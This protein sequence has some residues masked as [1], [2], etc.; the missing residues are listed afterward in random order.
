MRKWFQPEIDFLTRHWSDYTAK[1]IGE[2]LK[3]SESAVSSMASKLGL[4]KSRDFKRRS[5]ARAK[6]SFHDRY[7]LERLQNG[8]KGINY[9]TRAQSLGGAAEELFHKLVP[10]AVNANES[11]GINNPDFDFIYKNLTIDVKYSSAHKRRE[12]HSEHWSVR[13]SGNMDLIVGFLEK[14][15]G[16]ELDEPYIIIIPKKLCPK[17]KIEVHKN[18]KYREMF[19]DKSN[20]IATL[21]SY[22]ILKEIANEI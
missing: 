4:K 18:G 16:L 15:I 20:L 5:L 17:E 1:E 11:F 3:F 6:I 22:Q 2:M 12:T 10:E 21:N 8:Y 13:S 9:T 14:E 7:I 19:V